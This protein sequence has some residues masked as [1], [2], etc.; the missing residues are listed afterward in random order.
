MQQN[1]TVKVMILFGLTFVFAIA[2][3]FIG[4]VVSERER[5][6]DKVVADV[7][8]SLAR[9][10]TLTGPVLVVPWRERIESSPRPG[11]PTVPQEIR[12]ES[13]VLPEVLECKSSVHAERRTRGLY[14]VPVYR[15]TLHLSGTFRL[16]ARLGLSPERETIDADP[17]TLI[18]AMS[19][20]RGL[21]RAPKLRFD[22]ADVVLAPG[23]RRPWL[24]EGVSTPLPAA[25]AR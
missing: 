15:A 19:D 17:P 6:R 21:R 3:L 22:G 25:P 10:Q 14:R 11:Q 2:L 23:T 7:G 16:P 5:Y 9:A 12:G 18:V 8:Q 24:G 20:V 4:G 13:V 1:L